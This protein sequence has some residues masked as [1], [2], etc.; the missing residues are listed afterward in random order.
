[1]AGFNHTQYGMTISQSLWLRWNAPCNQGKQ[2]EMEN[3]KKTLP[4]KPE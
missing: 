4:H 3:A 1:M 2:G